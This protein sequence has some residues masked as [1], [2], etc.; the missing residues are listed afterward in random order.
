MVQRLSVSHCC[1]GGFQ[2][3][4]VSIINLL[5]TQAVQLHRLLQRVCSDDNSPVAAQRKFHISFQLNA[6]W[7]FPDNQTG[8]GR[9]WNLGESSSKYADAD[10]QIFI[11]S[12]TGFPLV[13]TP[14]C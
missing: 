13:S 1:S 11:S 6:N 7:L 4:K 10:L 2:S 12:P 3:L 8:S 5:A 14:F 9:S